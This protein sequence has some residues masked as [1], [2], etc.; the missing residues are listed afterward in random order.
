MKSEARA[1]GK[2]DK[3]VEAV[4]LPW[5]EMP[6]MLST[7]K[8]FVT[9]CETVYGQ[10]RPDKEPFYCPCA[11]DI[12]RWT[13]ARTSGYEIFAYQ[14]G[15]DGG[16]T[17]T[18]MR[19]QH[20]AAQKFLTYALALVLPLALVL[21]LFY[22]VLFG[23]KE[24]PSMLVILCTDPKRFHRWLQEDLRRV[25]AITVMGV[26]GMLFIIAIVMW[27]SGWW[28]VVKVKRMAIIAAVVLMP[29]TWV[30]YVLFAHCPPLQGPLPFKQSWKPLHSSEDASK[31][32]VTVSVALA[33]VPYSFIVPGLASDKDGMGQNQS[34]AQGWERK[35]DRSH[36]TIRWSLQCFPT[37]MRMLVKSISLYRMHQGR[38]SSHKS[39]VPLRFL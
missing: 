16:R 36:A 8:V 11:R 2:T 14:S 23:T 18:S 38:T 37:P 19:M 12:G 33:H 25:A 22:R 27:C 30:S 21:Q 28:W 39:Q 1:T 15:I 32:S 13:F 4:Q 6:D 5:E 35:R 20:R 29:C 34:D 26:P 31:P 10:S 7:H 3:E 24:C 9:E 17:V